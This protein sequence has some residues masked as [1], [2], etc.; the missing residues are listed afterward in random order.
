MRGA[1]PFRHHEPLAVE[2]EEF[3]TAVRGGSREI[4]SVE[5]ARVSMEVAIRATELAAEQAVAP[6]R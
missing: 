3:L 4:V 5:D 1:P 6:A 2:L